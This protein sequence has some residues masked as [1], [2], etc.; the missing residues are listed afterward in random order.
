MREANLYRPS[1]GIASG[2]DGGQPA[3]S[4]FPEKQWPELADIA[5]WAVSPLSLSSFATEGTGTV[6]HSQIKVKLT[7]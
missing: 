6:L 4:E 3:P 7:E 1:Q 5:N 2:D